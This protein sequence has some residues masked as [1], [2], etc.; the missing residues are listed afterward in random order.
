MKFGASV[1]GL[2]SRSLAE[3][4]NGFDRVWNSCRQPVLQDSSQRLGLFHSF[5]IDISGERNAPIVNSASTL[6]DYNLPNST[7]SGDE[8]GYSY[9]VEFPV[10]FF[11]DQ[12][13]QAI[14]KAKYTCQ[15]NLTVTKQPTQEN[16]NLES[17]DVN[18][19]ITFHFGDQTFNPIAYSHSVIDNAF[20]QESYNIS[21][22][23]GE[24]LAN[25]RFEMHTVLENNHVISVYTYATDNGNRAAN[26]MKL[27]QHATTDTS[28]TITTDSGSY[29]NVNEQIH[30]EK[31][32][33][34]PV[35]KAMEVII[36]DFLN[37]QYIC[38]V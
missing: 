13:S 24:N 11:F 17:Y 27:Q 19:A 6:F 2:P 20:D 4:V 36:D 1:Q 15:S 16:G 14:K 5:L 34:H 3:A 7:A 32:A 31:V 22:G 18:Q 38:W 33:Y 21:T 8:N 28:S 23:V 26:E 10:G 9:D 12:D 30:P 29:E 25:P 35:T 37:E